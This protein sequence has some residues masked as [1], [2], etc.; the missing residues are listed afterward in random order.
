MSRNPE[1]RLEKT[2]IRIEPK[3][4]N[5]LQQ[6]A[7]ESGFTFSEVVRFAI[8]GSLEKSLK[9]AN[10]N[11]Q[12]TPQIPAEKAAEMTREMMNLSGELSQ[13]RRDINA[14]GNNINQIARAVNSGCVP[15]AKIDAQMVSTLCVVLDK[16]RT[17]TDRMRPLV[18]SFLK[19]GNDMPVINV[20]SSHDIR[21]AVF[22]CMTADK[23]TDKPRVPSMS[24]YGLISDT[25]VGI[26]DEIESTL[27]S[28]RALDGKRIQG[29]TYVQSFSKSELS[30]DD[31]NS[32]RTAN[33]I[34]YQTA[35]EIAVGHQFLVVTQADGRGGMV[36][37]HIIIC[38]VGLDDGKAMRGNEKSWYRAREINDEV[39]ERFGVKPDA[40]LSKAG[41][42]RKQP[43]GKRKH[44]ADGLRD[45]IIS[46]LHD[47]RS[48]DMD[49]LC[50][51]L[52]EDFNVTAKWK[53]KSGKPRKH[54]SYTLEDTKTTVRD[55]RLADDGSFTLGWL[56][57]RMR[58]LRAQ[59]RAAEKRREEERKAAATKPEA[60]PAIQTPLD[61]ELDRI[62]ANVQ[63]NEVRKRQRE[64]QYQHTL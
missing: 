22:Y 63:R 26:I 30:A 44:A 40:K 21:S 50:R 7:K 46:A 33:E 8:D 51:V 45:C 6:L 38:S 4:K 15:N 57:E 5:T 31:P 27:R 43:Y 48:V 35:K 39:S 55:N 25:P 52:D 18:S 12:K 17:E 14:A 13:L 37:N 49:G 42:K 24:A 41:E 10:E 56:A 64:K 3:L 58:A 23:G 1:E 2:T 54:I 59:E 62:I 60:Q 11:R 47:P 36:H 32:F 53:T 28:A 61:A 20:K 34:G 9:I 16:M 29:Y 19:G